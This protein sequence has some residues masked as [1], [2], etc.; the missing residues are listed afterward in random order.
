LFAPR[1]LQLSIKVL[2]LVY[3]KRNAL[4]ALGRGLMDCIPDVVSLTALSDADAVLWRDSWKTA[5]EPCPQ[6]RLTL[7]FLDLAVRYRKNRDRGIFMDL[8]QE[9]RKAIEPLIG[10]Y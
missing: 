2:L 9:E 4:S 5:A 8:P 7:R 10:L 3:R 1:I 6:F